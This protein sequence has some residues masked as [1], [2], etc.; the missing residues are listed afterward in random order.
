MENGL[1]HELISLLNGFLSEDLC[2]SRPLFLGH[3]YSFA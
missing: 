2:N 3:F 1:V